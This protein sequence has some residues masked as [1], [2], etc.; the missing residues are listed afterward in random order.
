MATATTE[1]NRLPTDCAGQAP[2]RR[3]LP[4]IA[5]NGSLT[6]GADLVG[7]K[8]A[9]FFPGMVS[10]FQTWT[11]ALPEPQELALDCRIGVDGF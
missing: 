11:Y 6:I 1:F 10:G 7:G 3:L 5:A 4:N 9:D 2:T 8:P